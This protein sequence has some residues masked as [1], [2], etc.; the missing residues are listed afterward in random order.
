M[1]TVKTMRLQIRCTPDWYERIKERAQA[2]GEPV[3]KYVTT[4][5]AIGECVLDGTFREEDEED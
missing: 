1:K 4:C 2:R 3:T 5:I